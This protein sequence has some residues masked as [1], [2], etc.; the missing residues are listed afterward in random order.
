AEASLLA[1]AMAPM[2]AT[3]LLSRRLRLVAI[4]GIALLAIAAFTNERT[5]LFRVTPG[6]LKAMYKQMR[7]IPGTHVTQTGWNAYSRIDSVE[8]LPFPALARFYIDSDA[9]TTAHTWDGN[10]QSV[11]DMSTWYRAL[12]FTITPHDQTM[13]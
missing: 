9:W 3:V 10:L 7:D 4:A 11:A 13:V 8:G 6:E 5:G 12:P 2:L 1:A